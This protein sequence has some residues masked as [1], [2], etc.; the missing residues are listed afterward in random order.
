MAGNYPDAPSWRMPIDRDGTVG[1]TLTQANTVATQFTHDQMVTINN[2]SND[3]FDLGLSVSDSCVF[4]F[5][6]ARDIDGYYISLSGSYTF[7]YTV[8][9]SP[10][11]TNGV[12][13]T[14]STIGTASS[15]SAFAYRT[16]IVSVASLAM[17]AIKI[18]ITSG[19]VLG[20]RLAA[21]HLYGEVAPGLMVPHSV[22]SLRAAGRA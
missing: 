1:L 4:V 18:T 3:S 17:R 16:G 19:G 11:S 10:D 2:E 8:S 22:E 14:W 21:F 12:D 15:S 13:G 7:Q 6:E 20:T 5:P 9:V